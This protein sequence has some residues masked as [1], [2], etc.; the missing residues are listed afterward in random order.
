MVLHQPLCG[1][2]SEAQRAI[3]AATLQTIVIITQGHVSLATT[4]C[5]FPLYTIHL[6]AGPGSLHYPWAPI[7]SARRRAQAWPPIPAIITI[8]RVPLGFARFHHPSAALLAPVSKAPTQ[9]NG[10]NHWA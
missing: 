9:R 7:P 3:H 4:L 5:P 6:S 2:E 8:A 10:S 1:A